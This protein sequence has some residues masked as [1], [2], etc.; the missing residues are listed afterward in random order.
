LSKLHL[1]SALS[2]KPTHQNLEKLK[3]FIEPV[4]LHQVAMGKNGKCIGRI[5]DL[6]LAI[7]AQT[8]GKL[9]QSDEWR[10]HFH[11]PLH[12]SPGEDLGDTRLHVIDTLFWLNQNPDT[13]KH[14]EME[15]Y[16]W[17]VLP[18]E[19]QAGSVIEQVGKEYRWTLNQMEKI[20]FSIEGN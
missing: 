17:E 12:A 4:Y 9:P 1:S 14:L 5:K 10:I 7:E 13:C 2:A 8:Q 18:K 11:V 16:T 19:L 6:D 15:T 3:D 20:G